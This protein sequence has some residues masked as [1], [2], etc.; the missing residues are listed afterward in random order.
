MFKYYTDISS[1]IYQSLV[2]TPKHKQTKT[3]TN[4]QKQKQNKTKQNKTK[5][6][7]K[8]KKKRN[9]TRNETLNVATLANAFCR[10][11]L[12]NTDFNTWIAGSHI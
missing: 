8:K 3:K 11:S 5:Q 9:K 6:T 7:K 12:V 4:K 2:D 1:Y 10:T